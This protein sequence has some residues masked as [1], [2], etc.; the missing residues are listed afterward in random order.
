MV[1]RV[2]ATVTNRTAGRSL[3]TSLLLNT[4]YEAA[5]PRIL[6]PRKLAEE[7]GIKIGERHIEARTSLGTGML[8]D[9][10]TRILI[11]VEEKSAEADVRVSDAEDEAIANDALIENLKIQILR[12]R[13]GVYRFSDDPPRRTRRGIGPKLWR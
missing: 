11:E 13:E 12:P 2:K 3:E 8:I 4:G 1:V 9:P 6:L 10:A 7:L 5:G